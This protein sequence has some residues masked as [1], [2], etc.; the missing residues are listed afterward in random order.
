MRVRC[1]DGHGSFELTVKLFQVLLK[2]SSF[3]QTTLYG[4]GGEVDLLGHAHINFF[5][6][7]LISQQNSDMDICVCIFAFETCSL[8]F[9]VL[10][11]F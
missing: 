8:L 4:A 11:L 9:L 3:W 1:T 6:N 10:L 2:W 5:L 7:E